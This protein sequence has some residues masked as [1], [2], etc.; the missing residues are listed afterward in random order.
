M[1]VSAAL[2]PE[3]AEARDHVRGSSGPTLLV[4]GDYE[5][6]AGPELRHLPVGGLGLTVHSCETSTSRDM[7]TRRKMRRREPLKIQEAEI[8]AGKLE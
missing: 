3:V 6:T 4:F 8:R 1:N 7:T 2:V 5:S